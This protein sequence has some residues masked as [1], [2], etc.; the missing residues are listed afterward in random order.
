MVIVLDL[1]FTIVNLVVFYNGII[2]SVLL[3]YIHALR[4]CINIKQQYAYTI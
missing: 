2:T 3:Y 1:Y 4:N